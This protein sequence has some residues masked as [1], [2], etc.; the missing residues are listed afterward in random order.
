MD[1]QTIISKGVISEVK[2]YDLN[3]GERIPQLLLEIYKELDH[4]KELHINEWVIMSQKESK[5]F[6]D[7][8][9]S[10]DVKDV[11]NFALLYRGM[12]WLYVAAIDL[13]NGEVFIRIEGG[14]NG[15]DVDANLNKTIDYIKNDKITK[16]ISLDK[17]FNIIT[18]NLY[19]ELQKYIL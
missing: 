13:T 5:E 14:S 10:N 3:P 1:S 2:E 8:L 9:F 19:E 7:E 6:N 18:N 16:Y 11:H 4:N 15:Y 17:F 12:G